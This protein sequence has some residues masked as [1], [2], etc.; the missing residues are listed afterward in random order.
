MPPPDRASR[1]T[2]AIGLPRLRTL[3]GPGTLPVVLGAWLLGCVL[4]VVVSTPYLGDDLV[5]KDIRGIVSTSGRT[6]IGFTAEMITAWMANQGRFFPGALAWT[7][8]VFWLFDTRVAYKLVL[9]IVLVGAIAVVGLLVARL[10]GRWKAAAVFVPIACGLMQF[11]IRYDGITS[12]VGLVPL[13]TALTVG[14]LVVAI[15][16]RGARWSVLALVLYSMALVT[17]EPVVLFAPIMVAIVVWIRRSWLPTLAVAIP[18]V[19]QMGLAVVLRLSMQGPQ[20]PAY[21][22]H[23]EPRVVLV[24]F[25]KQL[26]AAFPLSQWILAP[27]TVPVI[28]PGSVVAGVLAVGIP[29]FLL[30]VHLG[31]SPLRATGAQIVAIASLG[32]W[33]WLTSSALIAI[34]V[35]WQVE[36]FWGNGYLSVVYGYFGL[37]L[38][39]LAGF[40]VVERQVAGRRPGVVL[41]WRY[42][43]ALL[44]GALVALTFAGNL[45]LAGIA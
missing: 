27:G 7:Y 23:L 8:S 9:G 42:G 15:S 37:A 34:T 16:R 44:V 14:A 20:A 45:T 1:R 18:A 33:M 40:L 22:V 41:A 31:R 26:V 13:T 3:G 6:L 11:R 5:N 17:Y 35:R 32:A 43:S 29:T 39:M 2:R 28:S 30:L 10:T 25:A 38:C 19:V 4:A 21:I 36:L 24:T 12:F